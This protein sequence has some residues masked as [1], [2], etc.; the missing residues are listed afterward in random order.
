[1]IESSN[2]SVATA[3]ALA[4]FLCKRYDLIIDLICDFI[5]GFLGLS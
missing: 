2:Q 1:M 4:K 5:F 3:D